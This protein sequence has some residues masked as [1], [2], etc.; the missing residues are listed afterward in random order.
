VL[1]EDETSPIVGE[2]VHTKIP[3]PEVSVDVDQVD[4]IY[5]D[6]NLTAS[7]IT[8]DSARITWR[9]LAEIDEK[10]NIDGIQLRYQI[11]DKTTDYPLTV[12][13]ETSPFIHRDTNYY[14]F[15]NLKPD[16]KYEIELDLIPI[17]EPKIIFWSGKKAQFVTREYVD[18]YDFLPQLS[19]L[20]I[21]WNSV[22]VGWT[23]IPSPDQKFVNIY[24]VIYHSINSDITREESS[25]F[26]I[27]KLDSPKRLVVNG[28]DSDLEYQIWLEAY[29][30]NGKI[31]KSNVEEFRTHTSSYS[32]AVP[33]TDEAQSTDY[34]Q[35]MVAAAIIAALA[36]LVLVVILYFYLKRHT[37]YKANITKPPP[38][39][40][41]INGNSASYDNPAFKGFESD[42]NLNQTLPSN[43]SF[44]LGPLN[45]EN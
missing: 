18:P 2:V 28:L 31:V 36:L 5:V 11:L 21:T 15:E 42:N 14:V 3:L 45:S 22:E 25:V 19:V 24:R 16:T 7:R 8:T 9:H 20:N 12:V 32:L 35:S 29:L 23:G 33:R 37:T 1:E 40:S 13:P 6:M 44:E 41:T 17:H 26:K 10:P 39:S 43:N 27:S 34:Y 38:T 4:E 30:T